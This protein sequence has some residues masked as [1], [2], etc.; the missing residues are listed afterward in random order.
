MKRRKIRLWHIPHST[1]FRTLPDEIMMQRGIFVIILT[2][3]NVF[4][5]KS[6][7][8]P[9]DPVSSS[10][11]SSQPISTL[12]EQRK[13]NLITFDLDDTLFPIGPVVQDANDAM[14]QTLA[15]LDYPEACLDGYTAACKAIRK[16]NYQPGVSNPIT[17]SELRR[18]AIQIEMENCRKSWNDDGKAKDLLEDHIVVEK[19]FN[20]WFEERHASAERNLFPDAIDM[21]K[22]LKEE[23]PDVCIGAVTNGRGNPLYMHKTIKPYFD[24]CVSGEDEGVFPNRKPHPGIFEA[25][26]SKAI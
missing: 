3:W 8:L 12:K 9:S 2:F 21:L 18:R 14:F 20:S 1:L 17:Y 15:D 16:S 19:S 4:P 11:S 10:L 6:F 24:F 23:Y 25:T 22:S 13:V 5:A 7:F 26:L